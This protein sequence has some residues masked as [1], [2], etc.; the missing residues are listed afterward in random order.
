MIQAVDD[1]SLFDTS[2]LGMPGLDNHTLLSRAGKA[3]YAGM[4]HL[5]LAFQRF[6]YSTTILS[7]AQYCDRLGSRSVRE[8][9]YDLSVSGPA[10]RLELYRGPRDV[11]AWPL[12]ATRSVLLVLLLLLLLLVNCAARRPPCR[13]CRTGLASPQPLHMGCFFS[14]V[15][16]PT[17]LLGR[18]SIHSLGR[19]HCVFLVRLSTVQMQVYPWAVPV[20]RTKCSVSTYSTPLLLRSKHSRG[21]K[22]H[23]PCVPCL[24]PM[25]IELRVLWIRK[26]IKPLPPGPR[27]GICLEMVKVQRTWPEAPAVPNFRSIL[28][29][30]ALQPS[31]P[32]AQ[33]PTNCPDELP[34]FS[35]PQC[36]VLYRFDTV[37]PNLH[38]SGR[39]AYP[40]HPSQ[41]RNA[42]RSI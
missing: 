29:P 7:C 14:V 20:L 26:S 15:C 35:V 19:P 1:E 21:P 42:I 34:S 28:R 27:C 25:S 22:H 18:A 10:P 37:E 41:T 24:S 40:S 11:T 13:A 31:S 30:A 9:R 6:W 4:P 8:A 23:F 12:R 33:Q 3:V 17:N 2:V 38:L 39:P 16:T 32:A 5:Q 36:C